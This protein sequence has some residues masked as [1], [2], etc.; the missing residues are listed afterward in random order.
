MGLAQA[1]DL[2]RA[3]E[4]LALKVQDYQRDSESF[5]YA[6]GT[7]ALKGPRRLARVYA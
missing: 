3:V 6:L 5:T 1:Y 7:T 2:D 4:V